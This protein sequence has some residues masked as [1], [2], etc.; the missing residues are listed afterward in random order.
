[1]MKVIPALATAALLLTAS[2]SA[3]GAQEPD[4]NEAVRVFTSRITDG[5]TKKEA[6]RAYYGRGNAY[7]SLGNY[8]AAIADFSKVI[9]LFPLSPS[10]YI[11]RARICFWTS[12]PRYDQAAADLNKALELNPNASEAYDLLGD[13][14]KIQNDYILALSLYGKAIAT[15]PDY[16]DA[17]WDRGRVHQFRGEFTQAAADFR[18]TIQ[19]LPTFEYPYLHLLL[20]TRLAKAD[21]KAVAASFRAFIQANPSTEWVRTLSSFCLGQGK[22]D[23]A[24]ILALAGNG[25]DAADVKARRAEAFF[26]LGVQRLIAGNRKGA[27]DFFIQALTTGRNWSLDVQALIALMQSGKL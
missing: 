13:L 23:E 19:L 6:G 15:N 16:G 2:A 25:K 14:A 27:E 18:K 1:M 9:E 7:A 8:E 21:D 4:P 17:Y 12:P 10:V 5:A 11:T 24:G 26:Y 20:V 3:P 22:L